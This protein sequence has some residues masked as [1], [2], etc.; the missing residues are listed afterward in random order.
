MFYNS[1]IRVSYYSPLFEWRSKWIFLWDSPDF[2]SCLASSSSIFWLISIK[3]CYWSSRASLFCFIRL[4]SDV[5]PS[6]FKF[7]DFLQF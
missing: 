6:Q 5:D 7:K 1:G 3:F 2:K 4:G